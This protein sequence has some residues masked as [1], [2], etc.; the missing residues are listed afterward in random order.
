[1]SEKV[2]DK[3]DYV[4]YIRKVSVFK[5]KTMEKAEDMGLKPNDL[6]II[7]IYISEE[8]SLPTYELEKIEGDPVSYMLDRPREE[9]DGR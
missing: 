7:R 4:V 8:D 5:G 3:L 2:E 6:V 9:G 1:M